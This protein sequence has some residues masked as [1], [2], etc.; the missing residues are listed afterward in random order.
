MPGVIV[1]FLVGLAALTGS[2]YGK[3]GPERSPA[4]EG[5]DG[6]EG[7]EPNGRARHARADAH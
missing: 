2:M 7:A 3:I 5:P 1:T 4:D 6:G